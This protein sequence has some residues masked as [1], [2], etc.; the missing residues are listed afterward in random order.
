[1]LRDKLRVGGEELCEYLPVLFPVFP[2]VQPLGE[3]RRLPTNLIVSELPTFHMLNFMNHLLSYQ[4]CE[5]QE[6][7][8]KAKDDA[9]FEVLLLL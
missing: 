2:A 4:H 9:K 5:A 3:V 7:R 8:V 6:A 1:M